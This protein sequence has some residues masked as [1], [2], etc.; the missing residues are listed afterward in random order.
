MAE[1]YFIYNDERE[2]SCN[3][4][5]LTFFAALIVGILILCQRLRKK[6]KFP[7]GPTGVPILGYLPFLGQEPYKELDRLKYI[8]GN[9]F[10]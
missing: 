10:R 1:S 2:V 5:M 9:V 3:L 7:P 4:K 6:G 8:Y